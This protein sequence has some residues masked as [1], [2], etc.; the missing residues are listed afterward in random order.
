M[1]GEWKDCGDKA[2]TCGK[3]NLGVFRS[4]SQNDARGPN[5]EERAVKNRSPLLVTEYFIVHE[6][7]G[8]AWSVAQDISKFTFFIS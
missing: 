6:S 4:C 1:E 7:A 3:R 5:G 2:A 8:I